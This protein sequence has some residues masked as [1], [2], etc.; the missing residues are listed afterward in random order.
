MR[1]SSRVI[2]GRALAIYL[3]VRESAD[4]LAPLLPRFSKLAIVR[5]HRAEAAPADS[6]DKA[7][8]DPNEAAP[9]VFDYNICARQMCEFKA[10]GSERREMVAFVNLV[11]VALC[12]ARNT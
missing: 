7:R 9:W 2:R 11:L 10:N 6:G 3:E 5:E 4:E 8:E 12:E 1:G